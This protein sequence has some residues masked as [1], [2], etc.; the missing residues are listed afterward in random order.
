MSHS[1]SARFLEDRLLLL[2]RRERGGQDGKNVPGEA[3]LTTAK[4]HAPSR[5]HALSVV[6]GGKLPVLSGNSASF[7]MKIGAAIQYQPPS[8]KEA[9]CEPLIISSVYNSQ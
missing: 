8:Q 2:L 5:D 6:M 7:I 3:L 1:C 4:C 9:R